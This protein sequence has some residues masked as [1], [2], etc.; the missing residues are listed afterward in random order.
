MRC[1]ESER[2]ILLMHE[3]CAQSRG[4][5]PCVAALRGPKGLA[6]GK[7]PVLGC[8]WETRRSSEEVLG[9]WT[10]PDVKDPTPGLRILRNSV[11][12]THQ[13]TMMP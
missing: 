12:H 8:M 3:T 13:G 9:G 5:L 7:G 10:V 2:G 11:P 6:E 1:Q 4:P